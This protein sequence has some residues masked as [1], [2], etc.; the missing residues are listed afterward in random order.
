MMKD[1]KGAGGSTICLGSP[2]T[3]KT[4]V[5]QKRSIVAV[6]P[7][8]TLA[9]VASAHMV[10]HICR[11][12]L[13]VLFPIFRSEFSLNYAQ[14]GLIATGSLIALGLLQ[15]PAS[16]FV[17]WIA[18]KTLLGVGFLLT[19]I[20]TFLTGTAYS[21]QTLFLWQLLSGVSESTYHPMA[22]SII[23]SR[24]PK[25]K[26]GGAMGIH[27]S[28]GS[29][30]GIVGPI[31][32]VFLVALLDWR[33][34]LYI[35]AIPSLAMGI[36]VIFLLTDE[37]ATG[38]PQP[39]RL[40]VDALSN[41]RDRRVTAILATS[42]AGTFGIGSIRSFTS[43]Y[44][45]SERNASLIQSGTL[46]SLMV[47]GGLVGSVVFGYLSDRLPRKTVLATLF[48]LFSVSVFMLAF[49][50][51]LAVLATLLFV[52][53][54]TVFGTVPIL[55]AMIISSTKP[56]LQDAILGVYFTSDFVFLGLGPLITG[57]LIDTAG[58][59]WMFYTISLLALGASIH[60][61]S[62]RQ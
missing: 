21:F 47:A 8:A 5:G 2:T 1:E 39:F 16:L 55:Q 48:F 17:K 29:I 9:T 19:S 62:L 26:I 34:G 42:A 14:L 20:T 51:S 60:S 6:S 22:T 4:N 36:A 7:L 46:Y 40:A 54:A 30:G 45:V 25:E 27:I 33:S 52:V 38:A 61:L 44:L 53:G 49:P 31:L 18:R 11:D 41:L 50:S 32:T 57:M 3:M 59:S 56:E 13:P 37:K 28:G 23:A 35:I 15:L 12:S 58:F 10:H 24:F 43:A